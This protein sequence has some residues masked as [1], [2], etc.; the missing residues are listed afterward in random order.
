[1]DRLCPP[2]H[3]RLAF[4]GGQP[5]NYKTQLMWNMALDMALLK[6]RVLFVSLEQT[7]GELAAQAVCRFSRIP[8]DRLE[9]AQADDGARLS[10]AEEASFVEASQKLASLDMHLRMHGADDHGRSLQDV[11]G[12]ATRNRF[13]AIFIDHIGMIGRDD[14]DELKQLS[15]AIDKLRALARGSVVAGYRPFVCA[16]TPLKRDSATADE[17]SLPAITDFRGSNRLEYDSDMAM[18]LRKL[19]R[20][21]P[22]DESDEPDQVN[23]YVLKNRKGRCP[24]VLLFEAQGAIS[25][26]TER[27]LDNPQPPQHWQAKEDD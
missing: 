15:Q 16:T 26:V 19:P 14:G 10:D 17:D 22:A 20:K 6:Q 1:M 18:I 12:S 23:A 2:R 11:I 4:I 5:G 25:L 8:L 21:N 27:R 3:A 13:D 24:V 9:R 7:P